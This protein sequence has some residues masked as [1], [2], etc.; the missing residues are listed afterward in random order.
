MKVK[1]E[2]IGALQGNTSGK[3]HEVEFDEA[4]NVLALI[5]E[6]AKLQGA[7]YGILGSGTSSL[8]SNVLILVNDREISVLEGLETRLCDGDRVTIVPVSHGG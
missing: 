7:L 2:L 8:K 4:V 5:R 3:M 6:L 1:V